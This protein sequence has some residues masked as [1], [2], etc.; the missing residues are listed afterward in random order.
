MT[1]S[2][3]TYSSHPCFGPSARK[4]VDRIHLPVAPRAN[5]RI[6]Y[7]SVEKIQEAIQPDAALC[8]LDD[9][10][11]GG[12]EIGVVG[13]T[14]PGDP[15]VIP[16]LTFRTLEL[17]RAKYPEMSLCMTTL[18]IGADVHAETLAKLGISHV[19]LLVDAVSSSVAEKLYA[20]IRPSKKNLPIKE[21]AVLLTSEQANAVKAFKAAGLTVKINTT[22]YPDNLD[23]IG[24]IAQ[25]M[26]ELGA[27]I[28]AVTPFIA[29]DDDLS[30]PLE[31]T[32]SEMMATTREM[33]SEYM[34]LMPE[35]DEC[36]S[37]VKT[38]ETSSL[39]KPTKERPNVAAVSSNGMDVD[40]HLGHAVK[41]LIYG[42]REDGLPCLLETRMA[43]K[44]GSGS[45]RWEELGELLSD[46]FIILTASAGD[47]P[48]KILSQSG[49]RVE[50]TDENVEGMVDAIYGGGKKKKCKK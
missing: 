44:A 34:E 45:S 36:G 17:V 49:L 11:A 20:W 38:E 26:K 8:W 3:S 28:M 18:G 24:K 47:S 6:R 4:S 33:A 41:I 23:H 48:K 14:G 7:S 13:I 35:W 27:D 5:S 19:T 42:P 15:L 21:A 25:S 16:E 43:P 39:P 30:D 46:C 29:N 37:L 9:V 1:D 31:T 40:M 12:R 10:I 50:V 22:V 32:S 2:S